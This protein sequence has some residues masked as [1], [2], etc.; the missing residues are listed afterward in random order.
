MQN[1]NI[2]G[3]ANCKECGKE[4]VAG[5]DLYWEL[6]REDI[7]LRDED[8]LRDM[9]TMRSGLPT[10]VMSGDDGEFVIYSVAPYCEVCLN[11]HVQKY[12]ESHTPQDKLTTNAFLNDVVSLSRKNY[13]STYT[14]Q[15]L[16]LSPRGFPNLVLIREDQLLFLSLRGDVSVRMRLGTSA[17]A[18][19]TMLISPEVPET[20]REMLLKERN[21]ER[22]PNGISFLYMDEKLPDWQAPPEMQ[23]TSLTGLLVSADTYPLFRSNLL[24]L[25]PDSDNGVTNFGME[26]HASNLFR[27]LPD[28]EHF[29]FYKGLVSLV[30]ELNCR[31]YR[32]GFNFVRG[33]DLLR[34]H[35]SQLLGACFR[36]MLIAA[37]DY[38]SEA[39]IWPVMEIDRTKEQDHNFA[40][41]V[42]W[43]DAATAHL[44]SA[45]ED[46]D[47]LIDDDYLIDNS[48]LGDVHYVTKRSVVGAAVDCLV[49]L[50]HHKWLNEAGFP[51]TDYKSRL[52]EIASDLN[53]SVVDDFVGCFR[54]Q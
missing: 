11:R 25:L 27:S 9:I 8:N 47:A 38:E 42:R 29:E 40:G 13:W 21:R 53:Q 19:H 17:I 46:V 26:I 5:R 50:L 37:Q 20:L 49:Y 35:Q 54:M 4:G 2:E 45:G 31:I 48:R 24:G 43:V 33:H 16:N 32:R 39:Q 34:K 36:S 6:F 15:H 10:V 14:L 1:K 30:N 23:V 12:E 28:E 18:A 22:A 7:P 41:Y 52:A 3:R 44:Q 51:L